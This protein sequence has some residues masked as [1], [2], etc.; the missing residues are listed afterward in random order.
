MGMR[1][2]SSKRN[3]ESNVKLQYLNIFNELNETKLHPLIS[4]IR[5]VIFLMKQT[6]CESGQILRNQCQKNILETSRK[7]LAPILQETPR[8]N[9]SK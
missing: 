4:R 1:S 7:I 8:G 9:Y 2:T 3:N 5:S 6:V